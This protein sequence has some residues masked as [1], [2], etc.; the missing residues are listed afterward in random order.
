MTDSPYLPPVRLEAQRE[1]L[2]AELAEHFAHDHL[3]TAE[4]ERRL[5]RA[6]RARTLA[7]LEQLKT[8]LPALPRTSTSPTSPAPPGATHRVEVA[9]EG[10]VRDQQTVFALMGGAERSGIW[11][12]ARSVNAVVIMGGIGLDFREARFAP[13]VTEVNAVA[14]MG[15][16]EILVPPGV[17][18]ES[19]GIGILGGFE[20]FNHEVA[21]A[22]APLLRIS[23]MA[24]IDAVE[25]RQRLP[26]ESAR[27][28]K[29]RRREEHRRL[30]RSH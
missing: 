28:A 6:Y 20:S 9:R 21:D 19:N 16:I 4:F 24:L 15:G 30:R 18:V 12:P 13:G 25:I 8:D 23:G 14:I 11:T 29:L 3:D 2:V 7:E 27:E 22:D 26:G 5:D 1:R 17:R 10:E